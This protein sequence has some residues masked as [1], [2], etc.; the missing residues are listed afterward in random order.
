MSVPK[1]NFSGFLDGYRAQNIGT[2]NKSIEY[3][4]HQVSS[5]L[6]SLFKEK[7][8]LSN[9]Y[10][11]RFF[12]DQLSVDSLVVVGEVLKSL[13]LDMPTSTDVDILKDEH[14]KKAIYHYIESAEASNNSAAIDSAID[15]AELFKTLSS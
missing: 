15:I 10:D 4:L 12:Q 8:R 14:V 3:H 1:R 2:A 7:G 13:I 5:E 9:K 11:N 6:Q